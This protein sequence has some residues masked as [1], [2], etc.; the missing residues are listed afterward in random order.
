MGVEIRT[1]EER[2]ANPLS[3]SMPIPPANP[4]HGEVHGDRE[5][6]VAAEAEGADGFG[7]HVG[8][9]P[10]AVYGQRRSHPHQKRY[11]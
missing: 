5:G 11:E 10:Q 4:E 1:V 8:W 2:T 6:E 9:H 3:D 7:R